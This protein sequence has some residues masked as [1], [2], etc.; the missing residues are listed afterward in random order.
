MKTVEK[1]KKSSQTDYNKLVKGKLLYDKK[2]VKVKV[3]K[4]ESSK[5]R[6]IRA[7][8]ISKKVKEQ[9]L[10]IVGD[11]V[12]SAAMKEIVKF[13][14]NKISY[15]LHY[16]FK[17][18]AATCLSKRAAN[19][20]DGTRLFFEL[21]DAAGL[22]EYYNFYYVHVQCPKWGHV[23][24]IVETKKTKKWRYVDVSS[25]SHGCWGYVVQSCPRGGRSSKYPARPF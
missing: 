3:K 18:S 14:D 23:Y 21:C 11:K 10:K 8:G 6:K 7:K 19:C 1:P 2:T 20:C 13:M 9:A 5:K 24:A 4:V 12:G 22:T 25:D 17:W 15:H 16:G